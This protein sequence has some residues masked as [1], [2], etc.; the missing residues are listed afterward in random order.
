MRMFYI[1][2]Y[3]IEWMLLKWLDIDELINY[4]LDQIYRFCLVDMIIF[5]IMGIGVFFNR[6]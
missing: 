6:F 5:K 4:L 2:F 3:I 1:Y